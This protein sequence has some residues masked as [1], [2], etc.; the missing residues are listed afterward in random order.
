M[1][2]VH[3][4]NVQLGYTHFQAS[5]QLQNPS[6]ISLRSSVFIDENLCLHS[7]IGRLQQNNTIKLA[8]KLSKINQ[9]IT[10]IAIPLYGK[11]SDKNQLK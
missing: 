5:Q 1:K 7:L 4:Y 8:I 10:I 11:E 3:K 9:Y 6:M 2:N